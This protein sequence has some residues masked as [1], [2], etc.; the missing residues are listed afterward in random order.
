MTPEQYFKNPNFLRD[1][2]P[3]KRNPIIKAQTREWFTQMD[4]LP[5]D[6]TKERNELRWAIAWL[7]RPLALSWARKYETSQIFQEVLD[8]AQD[9]IFRAT[10]GFRVE[11]GNEFSTYA[12]WAIRRSAG[13]AYIDF[14]RTVSTQDVEGVKHSLGELPEDRED[15]SRMVERVR[16][17][18]SKMSDRDANLLRRR[19]GLDGKGKDCLRVI[20]EEMNLTKER[21][22]QIQL[23]ALRKL[24]PYL[25]SLVA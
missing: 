18:V 15:L 17:A 21:V 2:T 6:A 10:E 25:E 8:A 5:A 7:N 9:A 13:K 16:W 19:F 4:A 14:K 24:R 1:M 23:S 20:G 3:H 12:T 22:R 11:R